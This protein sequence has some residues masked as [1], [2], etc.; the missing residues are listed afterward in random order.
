[1]KENILIEKV[2]WITLIKSSPPLT[3]EYIADCYL[4]YRI[5]ICFLQE[6]H[7]TTRIILTE[8]D[9]VNDESE[10]RLYDLTDKGIKF[11][12]AGI[13][14]WKKKIDKSPDRNKAIND[15]S[16]LEKKYA[17]FEMEMKD[18]TIQK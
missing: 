6:H 2:G 3:K 8:E 13:I 17:K 15:I 18:Q 11:Y 12:K 4:R 7:L 14:P 9:I 16:F 5:M 10:L 1:M